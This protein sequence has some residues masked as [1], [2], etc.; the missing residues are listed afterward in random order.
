[1]T[2]IINQ[3]ISSEA[4]SIKKIGEILAFLKKDYPDFFAW[5]NNKVVPGLNVEQRQIYIATPEN[6]I[7][8][9]AGVIILKDD[10]FEK[11]ICTLYVFEK[12]RRQGVGSM[13]IELAINILGTKLPMI[14]VSDSNKEEF[15]D[16]LDKYGF[17]YYQEYPSYYK[18]DISEHSYN[19]YLKANGNFNDFVVNE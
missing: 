16:L 6:R 10:G 9:I 19:G 3:I 2:F 13:F 14:T 8:E 18:N 7:D 5:Y 17:E 12:Y 11:K 4:A 15:V 1:M